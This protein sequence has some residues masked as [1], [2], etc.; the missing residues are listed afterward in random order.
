MQ[1]R[2]DQRGLGLEPILSVCT[3]TRAK[4]CSNEEQTNIPAEERVMGGSVCVRSLVP[5]RGV[6][7][8]SLGVLPSSHML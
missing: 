5:V 2:L 3:A 8:V 6:A 1:G 4:G 7:L